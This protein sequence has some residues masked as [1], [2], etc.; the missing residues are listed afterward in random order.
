[1][2]TGT[3]PPSST[4]WIFTVCFTILIAYQL[5]STRESML[6]LSFS[7]IVFCLVYG[8]YRSFFTFCHIFSPF[9]YS[10]YFFVFTNKLC[11]WMNLI[12]VALRCLSF[13]QKLTVSNIWNINILRPTMSHKLVINGLSTSNVGRMDKCVRI[14]TEQTLLQEVNTMTGFGAALLEKG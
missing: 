4:R 9:F 10:N 2:N 8:M 14:R 13:G 11:Y 7:A 1:M 3:G 6:I 5:P 12:G